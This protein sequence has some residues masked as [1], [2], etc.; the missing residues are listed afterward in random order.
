MIRCWVL[1]LLLAA[2]G[3]ALGG[4]LGE[5][6]GECGANG[7]PL[8]TAASFA[9]L[10]KA[11]ITNVF[12]S[13]ITGDLGVSPIAAISITGFALSAHASNV[14]STSEQVTGKLYAADY[15]PP[16]PMA[17]TIAVNDMVLTH[18]HARTHTHT[19][20][21]IHTHTHTHTH[22]CTRTRIRI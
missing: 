14:Y 9:V 18:T 10:T 13:N 22:I 19:H 11:G 6:G 4:N 21:H 12:P 2:V 5:A 1:F 15:S 17:M 16:S 3:V 8:G 7:V 20:T